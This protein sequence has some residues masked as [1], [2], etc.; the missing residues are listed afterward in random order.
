V[1][2]TRLEQTSAAP[3]AI[4]GFGSFKGLYHMAPQSP[5]SCALA[6]SVLTEASV[7]LGSKQTS[8]GQQ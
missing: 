2:D 4:V 7:I 3:N 5:I 8:E 1:T 6:K